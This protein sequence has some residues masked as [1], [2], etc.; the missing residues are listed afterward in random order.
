MKK[1]VVRMYIDPE[2]MAA[3]GT[4]AGVVLV[5]VVILVRCGL[6]RIRLIVG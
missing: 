6:L 2:A 1:A 3:P 5:I 4:T